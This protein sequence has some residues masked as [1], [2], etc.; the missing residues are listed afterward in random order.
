[1]GTPAGTLVKGTELAGTYKIVQV[2]VTL[3]A[4]SDTVTLTAAAHGITAITGV[5][6]A[7]IETGA[8]ANFQ[9]LQIATTGLVL[10][11]VSLN[12]AGG[13]ATSFGNVLI[14]VLGTV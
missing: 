11:V 6:G 12:A 10:T 8:G 9:T 2:R 1:M 3:G 7:V 13:N 14:S 5:L 4:A